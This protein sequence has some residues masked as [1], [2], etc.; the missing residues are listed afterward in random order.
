MSDADDA[1]LLARAKDGDLDAFEEIVRRHEHRVRGVLFRLLD[2]ER[3]VEEATQDCF[4]QAWRNLH[5]FRGDAALFT[6]LYRIAVNE[7]LARMRRKRVALAELDEATQGTP[8]R[9]PP[10]REPPHAA[11]A[12]ELHAF[13]A[14]R[15]RALPSKYRVPLVLR[16]IAGLSNQE[17]A[18]ILGLSLSA[19]KSRIH[20]ARMQI[21]D[22]LDAWERA[23]S[24]P[25]SEL[26]SPAAVDASYECP[27][28]LRSTERKSSDSSQKELGSSKSSR[29]TSTSRSTFPV[30]STCR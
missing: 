30:P 8:L 20:R 6:W 13:L 1:A 19:A 22:D 15:V 21:R 23:G 11:E 2:D 12:S 26:E 18:E 5:R 10:A 29:A 25:T 16:D 28:R 14:E 27:C 9:A 4:V 24:R 3:D 17:V 7:A